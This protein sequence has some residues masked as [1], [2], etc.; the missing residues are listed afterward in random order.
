[1]S[2]KKQPVDL[3]L[4]EEDDEFEE[5]PAEGN[6]QAARWAPAWSG[7][8]ADLLAGPGRGPGAASGGAGLER[9]LRCPGLCV[10]APRGPGA[11]G[12]HAVARVAFYLQPGTL[13]RFGVTGSLWL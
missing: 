1:M 12:P 11:A 4:L 5:F 13:F 9:R 3:G 8:A 10:S 2:E 7:A 6:C